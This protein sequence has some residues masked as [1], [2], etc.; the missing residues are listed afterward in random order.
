MNLEHEN[1]NTPD[2]EQAPSTQEQDNTQQHKTVLIRAF[3]A[4][5]ALLILFGSIPAI[6]P[7]PFLRHIAIPT[8]WHFHAGFGTPLGLSLGPAIFMLIVCA[9]LITISVCFLRRIAFLGWGD[10]SIAFVGAV[11]VCIVVL[12]FVSESSEDYVRGSLL[13]N[14]PEN[15]NIQVYRR[16]SWDG[17]RNTITGIRISATPDNVPT[18]EF[19]SFVFDM[20]ALVQQAIQSRRV[21]RFDITIRLYMQT[22][23][24]HKSLEWL[25]RNHIWW[26]GELIDLPFGEYGSLHLGGWFPHQNRIDDRQLDFGL[27]S[28]RLFP[29][30][31][32]QNTIDAVIPID[33]FAKDLENHLFGEYYISELSAP[34][35]V[36]I[37]R[38]W[39]KYN[40]TVLNLLGI[41]INEIDNYV[42]SEIIRTMGIVPG[43]VGVSIWSSSTFTPIYIDDMGSAIVETELQIKNVA[44]RHGMELNSLRMNFRPEGFDSSVTWE[45]R[46]HGEYGTL[47]LGLWDEFEFE[48]VHITEIQ[49][50]LTEDIIEV[51]HERRQMDVEAREIRNTYQRLNVA[52]RLGIENS[53]TSLSGPYGVGNTDDRRFIPFDELFPEPNEFGIHPQLYLLLRFYETQTGEILAYET[54]VDYFSEEFEPDGSLRLYNNGLHPEIQSFVEWVYRTA[55][56]ELVDVRINDSATQRIISTRAWVWLE[57]SRYITDIVI[58]YSRYRQTTPIE[59]LEARLFDNLSPQMLDAL[60]HSYA[61]PDYVLDLT[62]LYQAGY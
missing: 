44:Q 11:L 32:I 25:P 61:D 15:V 35:R 12:F 22:E 26:S 20:Q 24:G 5:N 58:I 18:E 7:M 43:E 48:G 33:D 1:E 19:E 52:F 60:A 37:H 29:A 46:P 45:S 23:D 53:F 62:S 39:D 8:P 10:F 51:V 57:F 9:F 2:I 3:I 38:F 54:V 55:E 41:D 50:L 36:Y 49:E 21:N 31:E 42:D 59:A 28:A 47:S 16:A 40:E 34:V 17:S 13:R 27:R 30:T 14:V 4:L 56:W 6:I